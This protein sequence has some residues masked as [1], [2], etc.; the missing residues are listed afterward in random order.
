VLG[1]RQKLA[2]LASIT[3]NGTRDLF[4]ALGYKRT[5]QAVDFVQ[6]YRRGGLAKRVVEAL[7]KETW[8]AG[9]ELVENEDPE[10]VTPFEEAWNELEERL[11]IW[12]TFLRA[13][14]MAGQ[15]RY[16][17]IL[18]GA[19]GQ[20]ETPMPTKLSADKLFYLTPFGEDDAAVTRLEAD[21]ENP[22]FGCPTEYSIKRISGVTSDGKSA[23]TA[24]KKVHWTRVLHVAD[25]LCSDRVYG[26]SRLEAVWNYF[27][28]LE[29]VVGGGSE[30]FW[31]RVHQGFHF[32]L[33][34]DL[35]LDPATKDDLKAKAEEF[36][37]G[38]RRYI[39]T[40]GMDVEAFGSDVS[41]FA[42]Q[43]DSLVTLIA[44]TTEIPKRI[45][46]GS[47]RGEL[48]STQDRTNWND[49]I[50]DRRNSFAGPQ[51]VRP[52]VKLL[53]DVG[54][55]PTTAEDHY[56]IRWPEIQFMSE[57]EQATV[58]GKWAGLNGP[59]GGIVVTPAEIRDRILGLPPL[60]PKQIEE[61]TPEAEPVADD[62]GDPA[63]PNAPPG[64][65]PK[66]NEPDDVPAP[67]PKPKEKEP[68]A[69]AAVPVPVPPVYEIILDLPEEFLRS[70]Q[71]PETEPV[72]PRRMKITKTVERD[73][74][75]NVT[76]VVEVHEEE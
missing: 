71:A 42:A 62:A 69:A 51:V 66:P 19:P 53:Q 55:L 34:P 65:T 26:E 31:L 46:M 13:D 11:H 75:R 64:D 16:A 12:S 24:Q 10:T 72:A 44:G 36:A 74:H 54:I 30:A 18:I 14:I 45:L 60:T 47:E 17:V 38:M 1:L 50:T 23:D 4:E 27:D 22:R 7:P 43:V 5:L 70:L 59:A 56:D 67:K 49:R 61:A 32:N 25:G 33:D 48:A 73:E 6:R 63:D 39:A 29:K 8:R 68:V 41:N 2:S 40:K 15:G 3:F 58:A 20:M 35:T 76:A 52:F 37:N 28:D 21:P 57:D 9:A